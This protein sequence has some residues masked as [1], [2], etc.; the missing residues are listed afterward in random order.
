MRSDGE[1][2]HDT[3]ILDLTQIE[4]TKSRGNVECDKWPPDIDVSSTQGTPSPAGHGRR[5]NSQSESGSTKPSPPGQPL[6]M[7]RR[8][9]RH[10]TP[11]SAERSHKLQKLSKA[12]SPFATARLKNLRYDRR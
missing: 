10:F 11:E 5:D 7:L 4:A 6:A 3:Q 8:Q 9:K 2:M 12:R 1:G